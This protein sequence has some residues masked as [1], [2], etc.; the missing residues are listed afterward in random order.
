MKI[1]FYLIIGFLGL[2]LYTPM[3]AQQQ[4]LDLLKP[5]AGQ[6]EG[7]GWTRL[8]SG[9][10]AEFNQT[11]NIEFK[12]NGHVL[13]I[14]GKGYDASTGDLSFEALA[15]LFKDTDGTIRMS[16]HTLDGKHTM[17]KVELGEGKFSWWFEVPNGGTVKYD[18][19]FT[20]KTWKEKGNY[21]PDGKQWYPFFEMTLNKK[22]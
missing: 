21:S 11:E 13:L 18:I 8:P 16:G 9:E 4:N 20:D 1:Q 15:I 5:L 7:S 17:A 12:L 2:G 14:N 19:D 6:W 22:G 10:K 3:K